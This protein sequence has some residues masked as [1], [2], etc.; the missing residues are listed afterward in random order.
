MEEES[1]HI[2]QKQPGKYRAVHHEDADNDDDD[3]DEREEEH[4]D[5]S[6]DSD[7][8]Y[9][10]DVAYGL[11][12]LLGF[13]I[14]LWWLPIWGPMIAGYIGGKKAGSPGRGF[15]AAFIPSSVFVILIWGS[16]LG[17]IPIDFQTILDI[18]ET[19]RRWLE[20]RNLTGMPF[21]DML[22]ETLTVAASR[23]ISPFGVLI[24]F[25]IIGGALA[26]EKEKV[27]TATIRKEI[28]MEE[29][30]VPKSIASHISGK[31]EESHE[32]H[33]SGEYAGSW[34]VRSRAE[35]SLTGRMLQASKKIKG[36]K[37]AELI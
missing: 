6:D 15:V 17:W 29:V 32:N 5:D 30:G 19:T 10:S 4:A 1:S 33:R 36:K 13:G 35:E 31:D 28:V 20:A 21:L 37:K 3:D 27:I 2:R 34:M 8:G 12:Y 23:D 16:Y 22:L 14:F 18:P 26:D 7:G 9:M 25:A 24:L 11:K